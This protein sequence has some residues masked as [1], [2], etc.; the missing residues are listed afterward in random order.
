MVGYELQVLQTGVVM[1]F[2]PLYAGVLARAEAI[3]QS[4]RAPAVP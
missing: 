2:A 1:F 3:V 4:K